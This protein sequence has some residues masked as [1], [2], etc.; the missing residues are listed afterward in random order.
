MSNRPPDLENLPPTTE[1]ICTIHLL[2]EQGY[3]TLVM[4]LPTGKNVGIFTLHRVEAQ[5]LASRVQELVDGVDGANTLVEGV[6]LGGPP[7]A[8]ELVRT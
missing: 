4:R 5:K 8:E 1:E 6:Y 3:V 2:R 7:T